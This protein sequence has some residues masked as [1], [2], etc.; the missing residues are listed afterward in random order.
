LPKATLE[1]DKLT[2]GAVP[3]PLKFTAWVLPVTPPL[4]SVMVSVPVSGPAAVGVNFTL[5]EQEV[6][7]ATLP[8]QL[9]VTEKSPLVPMSAMVS[10][11][12]PAAVLLKVSV[13][14]ALVAP[15]F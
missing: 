3:V 6:L 1:E 9:S 8:S 12:A 4:L 10:A 7:A 11:A 2:T 14:A 13:W 5:I 15:T